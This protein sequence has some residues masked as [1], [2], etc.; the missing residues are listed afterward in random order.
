MET[1]RADLLLA[2]LHPGTLLYRQYGVYRV[3]TGAADKMEPWLKLVLK[4]TTSKTQVEVEDTR[5]FDDVLYDLVSSGYGL[6]LPPW[7]LGPVAP[8]PLVCPNG[9]PASS[10][11]LPRR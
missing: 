3:V 8:W 11:G 6:R 2:V 7:R 4:L 9:S 5:L 1:L 10:R